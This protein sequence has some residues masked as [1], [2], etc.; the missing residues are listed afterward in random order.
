MRLK[1]LAQGDMK[2]NGKYDDTY[3]AK[4]IRLPNCTLYSLLRLWEQGMAEQ[5]LFTYTNSTKAFPNAKLWWNYWKGKKGSI[6]KQ[7]CV[8][9]WGGDNA[10]YGHV[11]ICEDII[12]K[13]SDGSYT[14]QVSQSNYGG[15]YFEFKTYTIKQGVKTTG[16]GLTFLGCLYADIDLGQAER[17]KKKHQAQIDGTAVYSRS[18]ANGNKI[19]GMYTPMGYYNVI[20]EKDINGTIWIKV[21]TSDGTEV[22]CGAY[23]DLPAT[24]EEV[25]LNSLIVDRDTTKHQIEVIVDDLRARS[26]ATKNE[27]NIIGYIPK[28]I[29]NVYDSKEADDLTWYRVGTNVWIALV[30]DCYN[31]Y[32]AEDSYEKL[33]KE[34]VA[35]YEEL[36][37]KYNSLNS[38][39]TE[40]E[41]DYKELNT[42]VSSLE[43][44]ISKAKEALA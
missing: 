36:E 44:K 23:T 41:T 15:N 18:S 24:E 40:L 28:G 21:G 4:G 34:E 8:L 33:Y 10:K 22:W 25:D 9:V 6:P 13:N 16:V 37:K 5:A 39:Y 1:R 12:S 3:W 43:T 17:N 30:K 20:A 7:S 38:K 29:F 27:D 31:D 35:K 19:S 26:S 32:K 42:K 2:T 14:V 11:A